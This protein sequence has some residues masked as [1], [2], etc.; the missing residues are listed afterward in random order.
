MRP[1]SRQGRLCFT[2][3]CFDLIH[4]GH[5]QYLEDAKT[6]GDFLVIGLNSDQSV[7][8]I[9]GISRPIQHEIARA[10][11]LLG[12]KSVDAV[13]RFDEDTP[14]NLIELI[15]PDVLIK[16]GDYTPETIVG[17]ETVTKHG[18]QVVTIP[19]LEG[20]STTAIINR[21]QTN[22]GVVYT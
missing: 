6:L 11:V 3:G 14:A 2:N 9:K 13:I 17:R 18:G 20:F 8:K 5:V 22:R 15:Q 10:L 4:P 21:I 7:A 12:L 16:G 19:F 1:N